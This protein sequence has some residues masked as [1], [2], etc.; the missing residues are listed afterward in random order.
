MEVEKAGKLSATAVWR[1]WHLMSVL[2]AINHG[3]VTTPLIFATSLL[4][5]DIGYAGSALLYVF[6]CIGSLFLSVP[7]VTAIGQRAG[8][9]VGCG[10]YSVYV[11]SFAVAAFLPMGSSGQWLSFLPG[12]CL[13]GIAAAVLWTSQGGYLDRSSAALLAAEASEADSDGEDTDDPEDAV[14]ARQRATTEHAAVFAVYY[15]AFE[16][17]FKLASSF[18][19]KFKVEPWLIFSGCLVF[20][21]ASTAAL[22]WIRDLGQADSST[23]AAGESACSKVAGRLLRTVS[24]WKD[25]VLWCIAP[26]NLAFGFSAAFMNGYVNATYTKP[27]LGADFVGFYA[28]ATTLT[29]AI[30]SRLFGTLANRIGSKGPF[31]LVGSVA[32]CLIPLLVLVFGFEGWRYY[33]VV[34]YLLQGT[35]RAVYEST[36]KGVFAD[37]FPGPLS[38]GAF[39]NQMVQSTM[40]FALCFF[41]SSLLPRTVLATIVFCLAIL[42]FPGFLLASR[43]RLE[44]SEDG[45]DGDDGS[46]C[47]VDDA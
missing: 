4:S 42:I 10:L 11:G 17:V 19:L 44:R 14:A 20:A 15:L 23:K 7:I 38:E 36:S 6:T 2:F 22:L 26:T 47:S 37:F 12:S 3:C 40:S 35:A 32:F 25:P 46:E 39:A 41:F 8:L 34:P 18:A 27:Q 29:A 28:T 33:L 5:E 43:L 31:M 1:N 30:A 9:V 16:V 13:G 21:V 45:G 24:L